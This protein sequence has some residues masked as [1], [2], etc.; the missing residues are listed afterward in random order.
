MH[1]SPSVEIEWRVENERVPATLHAL[2]RQKVLVPV[3]ELRR[4]LGERGRT[5]GQHVGEHLS[6]PQ[7]LE[8]E[9]KVPG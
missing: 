6:L 5:D 1:E 2:L 7:T 3:V 9:V 4:K 8:F